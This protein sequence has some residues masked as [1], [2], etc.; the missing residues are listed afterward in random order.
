MFQQNV[1]HKQKYCDNRQFQ[2]REKSACTMVPNV[3]SVAAAKLASAP[4]KG[5]ERACWVS[6]ANCNQPHGRELC[7]KDDLRQ[8]VT[9]QS[10]LFD[11]DALCASSRIACVL[12]AKL[13][14]DACGLDCQG[15]AM[16]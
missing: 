14:E 9:P 7:V 5:H 8:M 10:T 12:R 15:G 6:C 13:P 2:K 3:N 11:T 16:M 4:A 1:E